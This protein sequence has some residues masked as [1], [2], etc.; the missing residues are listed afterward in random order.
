M[1]TSEESESCI[2]CRIVGGEAP[3]QVI[4]EDGLSMA[5]LDINPLARGHCLVIPKRHVPWWHDLSPEETESLFSLARSVAGRI[6]EAYRPDFV[7]MYARGRRI[8]HT[9]IFLVPTSKGDPVD[10]FFNALE[11]FQEGAGEMAR[12]GE[13]ESRDEAAK[14]LRSAG[15][16]ANE[17]GR[18]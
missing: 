18:G 10:R 11:G 8:P 5:I 2:F 16:G 17:N 14:R 13:Q 15:T 1:E 7:C 12:L 4:E 3:A 9:H 6:M